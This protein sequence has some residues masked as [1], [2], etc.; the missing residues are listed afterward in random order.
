MKAL[1]VEP[2]SLFRCALKKVLEKE[3]FCVFEAASLRE[4][5]PIARN[6]QVSL[7]TTEL[8]LGDV[9]ATEIINRLLEAAPDAIVVALTAFTELIPQEELQLY[10]N[11]IF[12]KKPIGMKE[13]LI[14]ISDHLG[15][16]PPPRK[17]RMSKESPR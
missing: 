14:A 9:E 13:L 5:L 4:A 1:L 16:S 12:M 15:K 2:D 10:D 6:S 3:G 17:D 7:I 11:V 8:M